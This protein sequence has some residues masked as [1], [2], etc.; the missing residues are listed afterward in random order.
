MKNSLNILYVRKIKKK[1]MHDKIS[2]IFYMKKIR[3]NFLS[4]RNLVKI[5]YVQKIQKKVCTTVTFFK[6]VCK[7]IQLTCA[8]AT[9]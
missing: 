6:N 5:I 2:K 7:K 8:T 1:S 3:K 4:S 9:N